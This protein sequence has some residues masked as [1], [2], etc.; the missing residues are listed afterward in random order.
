MDELIDHLLKVLTPEQKNEAIINFELQRKYEGF[1]LETIKRY[2]S[3]G[4]EYSRPSATPYFISPDGKKY[5]TPLM[6]QE[7]Y[8]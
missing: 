6:D 7:A 3:K 5:I 1:P 8:W 2:L 4:W